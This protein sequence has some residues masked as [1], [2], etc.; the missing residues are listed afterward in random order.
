[1]RAILNAFSMGIFG[2]VPLPEVLDRRYDR[3]MNLNEITDLSRR[4][5]QIESL[6]GARATIERLEELG[7]FSG[8]DIEVERRLP[9]KGPWIVHVGATSFALRADEASCLLLKVIA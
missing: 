9:L 5:Y 6:R 3:A 1:M 4:H 8:A 7:F 2:V